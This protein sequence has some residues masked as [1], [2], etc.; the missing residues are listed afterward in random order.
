[1]VGLNQS[2]GGTD[3]RYYVELLS[4][5]NFLMWCPTARARGGQVNGLPS[6]RS[7][8]EV[9]WKGFSDNY[10]IETTTSD[11]WLWRRITFT[12]HENFVNDA[13]NG[14][15]PQYYLTETENL[16]DITGPS[17]QFPIYQQDTVTRG[18]N[19][20]YRTLEPLPVTQYDLLVERMFQGV[21]YVDWTDYQTA[22]IDTSQVHVISDVTRRLTSGND[23]PIIRTYKHYVPLNK[24]MQYASTEFGAAE[25]SLSTLNDRFASGGTSGNKLNDVY[26]VDYFRQPSGAPA[27][28]R[29]TAQ[30]T[31]YWHEK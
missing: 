18:V 24:T 8:P 12:M 14:I 23:S 11:P 19:T 5:D 15:P 4:A 31:A 17:T 30:A 10:G 9:F 6:V 28:M 25:S 2:Q 7:Q 21:R 27:T 20:T 29:I 1:M 13:T 22:K 16:V 26:V 3:P